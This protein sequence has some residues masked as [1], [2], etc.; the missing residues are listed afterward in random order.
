MHAEIIAIGDEI[1]GGQLLDTN[2]QWLS[3]R[4]EELGIRVLFHSTVG[5]ELDPCA[6]VFR[7]A[8]ER[9]DLVVATGGLGPT[10]DDLTRQSLAQAVG[11]PLV[12]FPEALEHIHK[13][14]ARRR[15]PM[16]KQNE[17]Q[18]MFPEGGRMVHNPH[19]TAPGIDMEIARKEKT[20]CR[21][22]AL[23]G[24]PAEMVEMWNECRPAEK[25]FAGGKSTASDWAK[26]KSRR[27]C[28]T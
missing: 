22:F 18:A 2:S 3:R 17:L 11:Q 28:P 26:A 1:T 10:A 5:D 8:I 21:F 23:P 4:L 13:L 6:E 16:P 24:V 12:L 7:R 15:R 25:S 19:G 20:P 9:A 14:F 27:C